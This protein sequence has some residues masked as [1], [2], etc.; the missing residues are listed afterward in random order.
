M[1][2]GHRS[3]CKWQVRRSAI[4]QNKEGETAP[5]PPSFHTQLIVG[6]DVDLDIALGPRTAGEDVALVDLV[7][8][9]AAIVVHLHLA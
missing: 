6:S 7:V 3:G 1:L 2:N 9:D 8:E 5:V 4:M